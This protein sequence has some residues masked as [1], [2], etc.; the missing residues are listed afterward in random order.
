[1][2]RIF[3]FGCLSHLFVC[4]NYEETC[5][6]QL[7]AHTAVQAGCHEGVGRKLQHTAATIVITSFFFS[8]HIIQMFTLMTSACE[9]ATICK[10]MCNVFKLINGGS[11]GPQPITGRCVYLGKI[12][13]HNVCNKRLQF[14]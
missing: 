2:N 5:S 14:I 11:K 12:R 13:S 3:Y 4:S 7:C 8:P 10:C 6:V 1:M 9:R